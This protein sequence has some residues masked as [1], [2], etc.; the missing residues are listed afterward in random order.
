MKI[1]IRNTKAEDAEA[2]TQIIREVDWF[3]HLKSESV[4]ITEERVR[5]HIL[6]CLADN[7][8]STFVAEAED[9]KVIGYSSVHYLPYFFLLGPEGYVSELFIS[10]EVR[11]QGVGTTLLEQIITEARK[12]GCARLSLI[13]SRTRES[14]QRRFYEQNGWKER[15]E[16]AA[17]VLPL[18]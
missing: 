14:Y 6:L 9:H 15:T 5:K 7:S 17:F 12:R 3:E 16:V 13:N 1:N 11:G 8:H 10:A 2:I 18:M 4:E